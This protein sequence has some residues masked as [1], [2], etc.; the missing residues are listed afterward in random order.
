MEKWKHN[1][2]LKKGASFDGLIK[3]LKEKKKKAAVII[4]L[5]IQ[6]K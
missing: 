3:S 2:K 6:Q 4:Y 1:L 5:V